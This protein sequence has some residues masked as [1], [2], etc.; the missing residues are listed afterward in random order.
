MIHQLAKG[1]VSGLADDMKVIPHTAISVLLIWS[2]L[3]GFYIFIWPD[4]STVQGAVETI[5]R[6]QNEFEKAV[7]DLSVSVRTL[8]SRLIKEEM[9][10]HL[11]SIEREKD[12][13]ERDIA[14][15]T[16]AQQEPPPVMQARLQ[17]LKVQK[18]R[19]EREITA[20]IES[21]PELQKDSL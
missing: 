3:W 4:L 16:R 8:N 18:A 13:I 10:R 6:K 1:F 14:K 7:A 9:E 2:L 15:M 19:K 11:S 17:E 12:E 21:H 20:F 5:S